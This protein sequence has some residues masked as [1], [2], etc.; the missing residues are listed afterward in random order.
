[1]GGGSSRL[2]AAFLESCRAKSEAC[3]HSRNLRAKIEVGRRMRRE[4]RSLG[5]TV[6]ANV[7]GLKMELLWPGLAAA[8]GD[9]CSVARA[10]ALW[11]ASPSRLIRVPI[12][13]RNGEEYFELSK[14]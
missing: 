13:H 2:S 9:L 6:R 10:I 12:S 14:R 11:S 1:M 8:V 5:P 4:D 7:L 3:H